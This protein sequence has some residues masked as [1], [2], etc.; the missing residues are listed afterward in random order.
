M[1]TRFKFL[2]A[3]L[4]MFISAVAAA[5]THPV[6]PSSPTLMPVFNDGYFVLT[7]IESSPRFFLV[8]PL[9]KALLPPNGFSVGEAT[10]SDNSNGH[11]MKGTAVE[12][13]TPQGAV[14]A[15][16]GK[17]EAVVVGV[18]PLYAP[19]REFVVVYYRRVQKP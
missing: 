3:I 2:T 8:C 17:G 19:T 1:S 6:M 13:V 4:A 14:D 9:G 15:V 10:C 16:F 11:A 12:P 18:A 7:R 5:G